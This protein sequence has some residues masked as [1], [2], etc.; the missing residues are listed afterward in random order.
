MEA[1]MARTWE[2]M[3]PVYHG[4]VRLTL[5]NPHDLRRP[6]ATVR[7]G[8]VTIGGGRPVAV[9]SMTNTDTADAASTARQTIDLAQAGSEMVRITV[10]TPEAAAA[11][12]E[13]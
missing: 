10:N 4:D 8:P 11:V 3:L 1:N 6:G 12:P 7:I 9:Q 13:I 5:M 2:L